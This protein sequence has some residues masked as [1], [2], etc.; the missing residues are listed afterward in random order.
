MF[1]ILFSNKYMINLK[2]FTILY[3][4]IL[5]TSIFVDTPLFALMTAIFYGFISENSQLDEKMKKF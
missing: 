5:I 3:L 2:F 1:K 4:I